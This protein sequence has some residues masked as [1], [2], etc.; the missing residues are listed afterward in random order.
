MSCHRFF[1]VGYKEFESLLI[2]DCTS[3]TNIFGKPAKELKKEK[4]YV[5]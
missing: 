2:T 3:T 5:Y 4:C 1:L